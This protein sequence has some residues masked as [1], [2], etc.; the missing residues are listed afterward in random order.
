MRFKSAFTLSGILILTGTA[1]GAQTISRW[2]RIPSGRTPPTVLR[3]HLG[4]PQSPG[5]NFQFSYEKTPVKPLERLINR[6]IPEAAPAPVYS[7]EL[8]GAGHNAMKLEELDR[9]AQEVLANPPASTSFTHLFLQEQ[10]KTGNA[11]L[12][13]VIASTGP[14]LPAENIAGS[15]SLSLA[16]GTMPASGTTNTGATGTTVTT[17]TGAAVLPAAVKTASGTVTR[18]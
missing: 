17:A 7:E 1:I 10:K 8:P 13:E 14:D 6:A 11:S 9:E 18:N 5:F 2:L 3:H 16:S 12:T 15:S 4:A